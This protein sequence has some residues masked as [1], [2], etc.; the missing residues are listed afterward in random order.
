[1]AREPGKI[2][3]VVA[4]RTAELHRHER[5]FER[6]VI[7]RVPGADAN[8]KLL[9]SDLN[10]DTS[11]LP[12]GDRSD[13]SQAVRNGYRCDLAP[14]RTPAGVPPRA[15]PGAATRIWISVIS[16]AAASARMRASSSGAR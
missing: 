14:D 5:P 9:V 10:R 12:E 7:K 3:D 1:M 8:R 13:G 16:G 2:T 6:G 11:I 15:G 4:V